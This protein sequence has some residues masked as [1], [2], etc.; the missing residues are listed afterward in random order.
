M[1][2]QGEII[3]VNA[4]IASE[5]GGFEGIGFTIPSNIAVYV[6]RE[7]IAHGKVE[8]G[9]LGISIRDL[10]PETA[11]SL[12]LEATKGALVADV[13]KGGPADKAG[14]KKNDLVTAYRGKDIPDSSTFRNEVASTPVGE[15]A[16][17][18]VLRGGKKEEFTV[19]VGNLEEG[20]QILGAA[21]KERYGLE[22][23]P[24][25]LKEVEK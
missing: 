8:R 10:T 17:M 19:R 25:T 2:L 20:T 3:G 5:S 11:Q 4:A 23:R 7:L 12:H 16:K 15:E 13:V 1:N 14:L 21:L 22:V 9:W 18:A 24:V 6:S